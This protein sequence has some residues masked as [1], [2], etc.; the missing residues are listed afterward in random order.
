MPT[1]IGRKI[2]MTR[3]YDATGKNVPV[4]VIQAGPCFVSQV[5]TAANDGY[6]AVQIAFEDVKPRNSTVPVIGHDGAAGIGPKRFHREFR[7][8]ADEAANYQPGQELNVEVFKDV[9]FV[10]VVGQS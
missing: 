6:D 5:K 3:V 8:K 2:G 7:I 10:D 1:L 4:T 9:K